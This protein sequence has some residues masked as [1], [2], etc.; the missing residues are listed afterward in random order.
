MLHFQRVCAHLRAET[1]HREDVGWEETGIKQDYSL[2]QLKNLIYFVKKKKTNNNIFWF[3][4]IPESLKSEENA[5]EKRWGWCSVRA[6]CLTIGVL[7]VDFVY[8]LKWQTEQCGKISTGG[9]KGWQSY[10]Q[11][12]HNMYY[13]QYYRRNIY[14]WEPKQ[15][16]EAMIFVPNFM[17]LFLMVKGLGW[18]LGW[19]LGWQSVFQCGWSEE[20][21]HN[22]HDEKKTWQQ[23]QIVVIYLEAAVALIAW[24]FYYIGE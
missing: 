24:Y 21:G 6:A 17:D 20:E 8:T 13:T 3:G 4:F 2:G 9:H 19:H 14:F 18:H 5:R 10:N 11:G 12:W 15:T 7:F 1:P 22:S 23:N 16:S